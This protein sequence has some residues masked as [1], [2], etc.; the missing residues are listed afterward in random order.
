VNCGARKQQQQMDPGRGC[1][2]QIPDRGQYV[3]SS[4][5]SE[6]E[7]VGRRRKDPREHTAHTEETGTG[8]AE[9]EEMMATL[10]K[11]WTP[12]EENKLQ[13]LILGAKSV[14]AI[15][16]LLNRTPLAVRRRA[17]MLRLPLRRLSL[18]GSDFW[19]EEKDGWLS[20]RSRTENAT[21]ATPPIACSWQRWRPTATLAPCSRR[22]LRNG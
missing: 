3:H 12:E 14:E 1:P 18:D 10:T 16:K 11:P 7:E 9:G 2:A 8:R 13:E 22:W 15:A 4:H 21:S 20:D 6:V 5:R 19:L 17:S